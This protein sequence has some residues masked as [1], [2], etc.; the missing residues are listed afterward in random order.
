MIDRSD[1][2]LDGGID[3]AE[4]VS[5]CLENEKQ[6]HVIFKN[7]DLNA[8]GKID[9]SELVY[10]FKQVGLQMSEAEALHLVRKIKRY[11]T[12]HQSIE[13]IELDFEEFRDYLLLHPTNTFD[14][15][16]QSWR[17]GTVG[18]I[19]F[20]QNFKL[21]CYFSASLSILVW[22]ALC[23]WSLPKKNSSQVF[24]GVI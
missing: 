12:K 18:S 7:I 9:A 1:L 3:F 8:D 14:D 4:F 5:Y 11:D 22:K 2:N 15:L 10:A 6:L 24:G 19:V 23:P 21:S 13:Q 16:L 17:H 20:F